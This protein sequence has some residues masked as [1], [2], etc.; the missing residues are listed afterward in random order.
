VSED[1]TSNSPTL[2]VLTELEDQIAV[3]IGTRPGFVMFSP[4]IRE[5]ARRQLPHLILHTGQHY[6]YN[7]DR[8]FVEDLGLPEP[9]YKLESVASAELH[10]AQTAE[11][12]RG[13]EQAFI[14]ARPR[15]VLVGGDANTN[16]AAGLAARKLHIQVGHVEAGERSH[17]WR[18]PEEHNRVILDHISDYLFATSEKAAGNLAAERTRGRVI[19]TGSPI[20]DATR[21][22]VKLA[23]RRTRLGRFGVSAGRYFVMTVHREENVDSEPAL[24]KIIRAIRSLTDSVDHPVVFAAHPRTLRRLDE[25]GMRGELEATSGLLTVEAQ[26]YLSFL[27]LL[28]HA[29][30]VLTDSGGVQQ[31]ACVLGVPC[32]TLRETTEWTETVAIGANRL[33]G[34]DPGSV[35]A[36]T[37][38]MLASDRRWESPFGDGRGAERIVDVAARS[39]DPEQRWAGP[40][41]PTRAGDPVR[42]RHPTGGAPVK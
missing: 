18:M 42:P 32:V 27:G 26:G 39:L 11:M 33:A 21:Q 20:V 4:I 17:D 8:R 7:M 15:L 3:V 14:A 23:M 9:D 19:V 28:A 1:R 36:A 22:N 24:R 5:L 37:L 34:T 2:K 13:C 41:L 38:E 12:L 25:F 16:L 6:S 40:A 30:L 10:G 35:V 31:E 29:A